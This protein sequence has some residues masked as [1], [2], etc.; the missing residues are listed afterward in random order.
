MSDKD[1]E[2]RGDGGI[3]LGWITEKPALDHEHW[4]Y[5][6]VDGY[7]SFLSWSSRADAADA[8]RRVST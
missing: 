6:T 5:R 2:V 3:L 4:S 7:D 8:L 1:D